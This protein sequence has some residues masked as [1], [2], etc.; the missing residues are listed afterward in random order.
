MHRI[1]TIALALGLLAALAARRDRRRGRTPAAP[2]ARLRPVSNSTRGQ[3]RAR[4]Q[5]RLGRLALRPGQLPDRRHRH[6]RRARLAGLDRARRRRPLRR[7]RR[8]QLD[9]ALLRPPRA[10]SSGRRR[11]PPAGRCRSASPCTTTCSTCSTPA[12]PT[13]ITGFDT[14]GDGLAP[15][16]GSTRAD[17]PGASGPAQISFARDGGVLVVTEKASSSIET[18]AVDND[19]PDSP[20]SSPPTG[21]TP[22]GFDFDKR[23]NMLTSNASGSASSYSLEPRGPRQRDQ[24][25][26]RR[27]SRPRRAGSS[28]RRTAASRTPRT[29][30]RAR[31]RASR[32]ATTAAWPCSPGRRDRQHRRGLAPARQSITKRRRATS[33]T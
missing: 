12:A 11:C 14:D 2:P 4:L 6:R 16:P 27:R 32:S 28:P 29:A 8:Q 15:I 30:A 26:R 25:R 20:R 24:R 1:R 13:N 7:Q 22:F 19:V 3:R 31:S 9:H 23:G 33:T 21:A 10:A 5:P 17:R 18:Y